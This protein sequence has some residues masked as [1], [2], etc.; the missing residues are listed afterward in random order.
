MEP[1]TREDLAEIVGIAAQ[2]KSMSMY[3]LAC[4]WWLTEREIKAIKAMTTRLNEIVEGRG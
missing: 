4:D 3:A 1:E 2:L